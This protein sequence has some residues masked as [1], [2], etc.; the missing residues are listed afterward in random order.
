MQ[1]FDA[2][3]PVWVPTTQGRVRLEGFNFGLCPSVLITTPAGPQVVQ[4]CLTTYNANGQVVVTPNPTVVHD[5]TYMVFTVPDGDGS[6]LSD[7][8]AAGWQMFLSVATQSAPAPQLLRYQAPVITRCQH[9]HNNLIARIDP[10]L[11][12]RLETEGV[13]AQIWAM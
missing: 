11:W 2:R 7:N 13:E 9:I 10:Q 12:E 1:P 5:H 3:T 6:G 4:A 8:P